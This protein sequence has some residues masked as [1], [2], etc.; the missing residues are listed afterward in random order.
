MAQF[1]VGVSVDDEGDVIANDLVENLLEEIDMAEKKEADPDGY[2]EYHNF[3]YENNRIRLRIQ[4]HD[5]RLL[6]L[7]PR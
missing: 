6:K 4:R 5:Y 3:K 1:E 2:F 7:V